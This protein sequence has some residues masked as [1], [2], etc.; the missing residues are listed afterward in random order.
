MSETVLVPVD[1][2]PLSF[3]ALRETLERFESADVVV[4][5]VRDVFE[6][7]SSREVDTA[8]E[9]RMGSDAWH[10]MEEQAAVEL[11]EEAESVAAEY[12]RQVETVSQVGD[13]QRLIPEYARD[14]EVDHVVIGVH[15][16]EEPERTLFGRVAESVVFRSP[17]SVTVVR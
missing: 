17:V 7:S 3:R 4:L 12:D 1:G 6:P 10:E 2:S 8:D 9:P 13:P 5:H 15:G 11:L 14:H 16:R